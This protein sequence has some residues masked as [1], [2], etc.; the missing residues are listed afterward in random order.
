[1][2][3]AESPRR[4]AA[5]IRLSGGGEEALIGNPSPTAFPQPGIAHTGKPE[6]K[7]SFLRRPDEGAAAAARRRRRLSV[8]GNT[9][10]PG[11]PHVKDNATSNK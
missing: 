8:G 7:G 2:G 6:G 11:D 10:A 9:C 4:R 5:G 1:M 3:S